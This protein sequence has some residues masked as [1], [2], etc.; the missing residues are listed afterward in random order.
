MTDGFYTR[1]DEGVEVVRERFQAHSDIWREFLRDLRDEDEVYDADR[2]ARDFIRLVRMVLKDWSE[3]YEFWM[4]PRG[5]AMA[6]LPT[7][8][9]IVRADAEAADPK[10]LRVPL[11]EDADPLN[12]I[13]TDLARLNADGGPN[14]A[15]KHL[16]LDL[17]DGELSIGLHDL[18]N[19]GAPRFW[20]G[21]HLGAVYYNEAGSPK[22]LAS[23]YVVRID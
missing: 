3:A 9:F 13:A 22:P 4:T 5:P 8:G 10:P 2:L 7:I 23:V 16:T 17:V 15:K 12:L 14:I 6:G 1:V 19:A 20:A 21:E 11:D 18:R